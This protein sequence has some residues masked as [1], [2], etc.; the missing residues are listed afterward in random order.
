MEEKKEKDCLF[1]EFNPGRISHLAQRTVIERV[2]PD[3]PQSAVDE[4]IEGSITVM[5]LIDRDGN[6]VKSCAPRG[7]PLLQEA[8][9]RAALKWKF[10]P[11]FGHE[12]PGKLKY[13][14]DAVVFDFVRPAEK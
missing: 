14:I 10:K 5:I 12:K 1:L 4:G 6:V 11:N 3:Y 9:E 7:A 8:A 13:V 2:K